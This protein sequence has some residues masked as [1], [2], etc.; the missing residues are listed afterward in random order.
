M[1]TLSVKLGSSILIQQG[2]K[3]DKLNKCIDLVL[4]KPVITI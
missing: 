1:I 3:A 4:D 2:N